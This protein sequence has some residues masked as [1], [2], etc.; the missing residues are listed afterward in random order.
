MLFPLLFSTNKIS[1]IFFRTWFLCFDFIAF[2]F[3][4]E[5]NF[6]KK[7]VLNSLILLKII[8]TNLLSIFFRDSHFLNFL[9]SFTLIL[10]TNNIKEFIDFVKNDSIPFSKLFGFLF[11]KRF[12][13][14]HF[15]NVGLFFSAFAKFSTNLDFILNVLIKCIRS[16][17]NTFFLNFSYSFIFIKN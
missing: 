7:I 11:Y 10:F 2:F 14:L 1:L 12:I 5:V 4:F 6:I 8:K 9:D 16:I 15:D 3:F 13:N 17:A